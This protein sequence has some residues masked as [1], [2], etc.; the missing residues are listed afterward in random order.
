[1]MF[2]AATLALVASLVSAKSFIPS[3]GIPA[4]SEFGTRLLNAATVVEPARH[5]DQ[6]NGYDYTFLV[7]YSIKYTGCNS[8][9]QVNAQQNGNNNNNQGASMLY[10]QQ[11]V[12]FSL[13]PTD[14]CSSCSGGGQYVVNMVDFVDSYTEAKLSA[15][16]YACETVRE[17]CDC[18]GANDDDV[19]EAACYTTAGLTNCIN[20]DGG[21]DFDIQKYLECGGKSQSLS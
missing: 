17:N 15:Q 7:N 8:I 19:C 20:Y 16:E 14:S 4:S 18:E 21:D 9:T 5:L 6:N 3:G 11:L 12:R 2:R 13:C 1:M 10:T